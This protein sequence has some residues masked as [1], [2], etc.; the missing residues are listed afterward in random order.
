[1]KA[2]SGKSGEISVES[3][4][5]ILQD[6]GYKINNVTQTTKFGTTRNFD[7]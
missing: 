2:G 6:A 7:L 4:V 3:M 5:K 1:M